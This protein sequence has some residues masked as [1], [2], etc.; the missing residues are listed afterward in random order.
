MEGKSAMFENEGY[1]YC[2]DSKVKFSS[3]HD[4]FRDNYL[5]SHCGCV[6]RERALMFSID[7][8][9]PKWRELAFHESSPIGRGASARIQKEARQY[10]PSQYYPGVPSG[11]THLGN[12]CE[13][14]EAL[15]FADNSV[16]IHI[17]QDVFEHLFN[18]V[19]AFRE[20]ARTLKPGGAHIFT[21]P[22]VNKDLPTRRCAMLD[23]K[24]KVKHL[25]AKPEYHGN[26]VDT[27]GSLVTWN[28]GYDITH[29]IFQACG[30][31]TQM[32]WMDALEYGIRAE[33]I[34][35]FITRKPEAQKEPSAY[36]PLVKEYI[37]TAGSGDAAPSAERILRAVESACQSENPRVAFASLLTL[38]DMLIE[39]GH[40]PFAR[41]VLSGALHLAGRWDDPAAMTQI[42]TLEKRLK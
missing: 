16:D 37:E 42:Q 3:Q 17:T 30:L 6:P 9:F 28:W 24:G 1:C 11:K 18:P 39:N 35:V 36:Y 31:H 29:C 10:I 41:I 7:K 25:V 14:L 8:F 2:C 20:I 34:E 38:A 23:A 5:C 32:V 40:S 27:E 12:R 13:D 33:Y 15:S 21:V 22:I 19:A 26:P 4:W